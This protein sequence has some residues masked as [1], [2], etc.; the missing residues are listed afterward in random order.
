MSGT[1]IRLGLIGDNI[2]A[3]Q[4]PRLHEIAGRLCGLTVTYE[5]LVPPQRNQTFEEVFA[6]CGAEG[7]A[8]INVTYPYKERVVGMLDVADPAIRKIAACNTV[9][10]GAGTPH[11]FNTDFTGFVLGFRTAFGRDAKPGR[12]AMIGAGGVGKA[13]AF[14]L[15]ELGCRHLNLFDRDQARAEGLAAAVRQAAPDLTVEVASSAEE[16]V[17]GTDGLINCTPLGMVGYAGSAVPESGLSGARWAFDAV[18]T[19]VDTEFLLAA[20]AAGLSIMSGYELFFFQGVDAFR[21]FTGQ[22]VDQAALRQALKQG[23]GV[24]V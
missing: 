12:V 2:A 7:F 1:T 13:V 14:G 4:S 11:G 22:D 10:F 18:Y 5:R 8:G 16:A 21:L 9:L 3:S 17:E 24:N 15:V 23:E 19:P 6:F 20:K